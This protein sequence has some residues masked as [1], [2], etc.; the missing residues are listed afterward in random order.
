[1]SQ[2]TLTCE[3]I[4]VALFALIGALP[5]VQTASRRLRMWSEVDPSEQ[6]AVFLSVAKQTPT[7][8]PEGNTTIWKYG[9]VVTLYIFNNDPAVAPSTVLNT[10]LEAIKV[11]LQPVKVGPPGFPGSVQVLGDTTGRIRHAW[12]SGPIE[13]GEGVLGDQEFAFIPIEIEVI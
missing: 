11:L 12:V 1:M 7:Q 10:W 3:G 8:S 6:P 2:P 13:T 4:A 9:Y 5:G